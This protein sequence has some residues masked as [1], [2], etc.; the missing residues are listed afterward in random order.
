MKVNQ[1]FTFGKDVAREP[2]I[3]EPVL[4]AKSVLFE[5][6][7]EEVAEPRALLSSDLRKLVSEYGSF[8]KAAKTIEALE[9][10]VRQ[11]FS[12]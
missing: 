11:K 2:Q 5:L 6:E 7:V 3:E 4:T 12:L 8:V 1:R 9:V 10:F